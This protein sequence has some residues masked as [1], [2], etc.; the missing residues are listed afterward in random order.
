MRGIGSLS[1]SMKTGLGLGLVVLLGVGGG[2]TVQVLGASASAPPKPIITSAPPGSGSTATFTYADT[3]NGVGFQCKL[4]GAVFSSCAKSGVTFTG[5][6]AGSHTFQVAAQSG[7]GPL[8]AP[9]SLTWSVAASAAPTI[10]EHPEDL[11]S[12]TAATFRFTGI[13]SGFQCK[14][15][16]GSFSTCSSP[17][18]YTGLGL[19]DHVFQVRAV[20]GNNLSSAVSFPWTI[21][22]SR[23]GISGSLTATPFAP[24]APP[25][26]LNLVFTNPYNFSGGL[27]ITDVRVTVQHATT[28]PDCDG[29]A[30]LVVYRTFTGPVIVP[31]GNNP[32]SLSD[33]HVP[34]VQWPLIQMVDLPTNQDACQNTTFTLS[35]TGTA[36]KS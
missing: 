30:N 31:R 12:D 27:K 34:E 28:S 18:A 6:G 15:D 3:Q 22:T 11:T 24:G 13:G 16:G 8:S 14:L 36:T 1:R 5:L 17:K 33:L 23:F 32:Q 4:D 29:P 7:N 20:D 21:V 10:T 19:G 9:A 2:Q 25:Q 35:Y 26:L